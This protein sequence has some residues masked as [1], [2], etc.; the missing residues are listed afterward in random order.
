MPLPGTART[1]RHR[2]VQSMAQWAIAIVL[3]PTLAPG[4]HAQTTDWP[5]RA[6]TMV[7]GFAAGGKVTCWPV[8]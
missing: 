5:T 2:F 8:S 4:A 3:A 6:V 7:I 1:F